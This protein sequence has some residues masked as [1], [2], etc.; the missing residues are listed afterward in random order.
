MTDA[1]RSKRKIKFN[2]KD[3]KHPILCAFFNEEHS[4]FSIKNEREIPAS[5]NRF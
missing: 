5:K 2:A 3:E 1:K 4:V